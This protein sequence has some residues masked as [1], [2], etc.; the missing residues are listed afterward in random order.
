M[1]AVAVE[2]A[3]G[4]TGGSRVGSGLVVRGPAVLRHGVRGHEAASGSRRPG[5]IRRT[6]I[7]SVQLLPAQGLA[8]CAGRVGLACG[9]LRTRRRFRMTGLRSY[10]AFRLTT[11]FAEFPKHRIGHSEVLLMPAPRARGSG[12]RRR[13]ASIYSMEATKWRIAR[14]PPEKRAKNA[15]DRKS[16]NRKTNAGRAPRR[17]APT[18]AARGRRRPDIAGITPGPQPLRGETK[19]KKPDLWS[20]PPSRFL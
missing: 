7:C 8:R 18:R 13:R 1:G 20:F 9:A 10:Q 15:R 14:N 11:V 19:R 4:A 5:A 12:M 17:S 3:A 6:P 16:A 2:S